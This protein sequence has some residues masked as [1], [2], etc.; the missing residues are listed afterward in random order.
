MNIDSTRRTIATVF[1]V[2]Y[3]GHWVCIYWT[4]L[5][6]V[7]IDRVRLGT[8][9]EYYFVDSLLSEGLANNLFETSRWTSHLSSL[10]KSM[11]RKLFY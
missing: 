7:V 8:E 6:D 9:A 3:L 4:I 11:S 10:T 1:A 5:S 2:G